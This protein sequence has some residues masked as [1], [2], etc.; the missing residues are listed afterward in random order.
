MNYFL[1]IDD[2]RDDDKFFL[3]FSTADTKW[4]PFI[5]RSYEDAVKKFEHRVS[6]DQFFVDLDHDL[7]FDD[8]QGIEKNGYDICKYIVENEVPVVGFHIH[9][10][11]PVGAANMRQLLTHYGIPEYF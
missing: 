7:G 9:S 5:V 4:F 1:Y 8:E 2:I 6:G 10:M 11:N 3:R